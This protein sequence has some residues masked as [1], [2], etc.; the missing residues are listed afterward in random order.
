MRRA[1]ARR[2]GPATAGRCATHS[3]APGRRDG[4]R[5]FYGSAARRSGP[6]PGRLLGRRVPPTTHDVPGAVEVD[7]GTVST[8]VAAPQSDWD[9]L[10]AT[11]A[12][13]RH[14][15][16]PGGCG[17]DLRLDLAGGRERGADRG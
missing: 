10:P 12:E 16:G 9:F 5:D 1:R 7:R 2:H 13:Q 4:S 15:V 8:A 6:P 11:G 3:G 17:N 14:G